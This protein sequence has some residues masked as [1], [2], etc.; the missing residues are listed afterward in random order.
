MNNIVSFSGGKDSTAMLHL[1]LE[2]GVPISHVVYFETEWD[3]PQM[4][5]HLDMVVAKTGLPIIRIRFYRHFNEMLAKWG[6]PKSAGGWCTAR[7]HRTCLKYI[8]Y[9]K[10]DKVE[11]IGFS[12]DELHRTQTGWMNDRKWP[13]EFPLIEAGM[14][15][16]DSLAYCKRLGYHWDGLYDIFNR[17]SC[18]CCPK[19]GKTKRRL[20]RENFPELEREWQRLDAV[21]G[22]STQACKINREDEI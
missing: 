10:G 9:I 19:G 2:R 11:Y 17:V 8:R 18:F 4:R 15:E 20:I 5:S 1:L 16:T 14:S 22:M 6:W 12:A 21:A 3:F 7:K 13:V